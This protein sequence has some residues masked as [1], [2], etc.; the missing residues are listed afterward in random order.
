MARS[1]P[2]PGEPNAGR[3]R[4]GSI[5]WLAESRRSGGHGAL[6]F[7][8]LDNFKP[9][10]DRHGH[11]AGD[12]LLIEAATRL[13]AYVRAMD[14][15]ARFGGDEF[16]VLLSDL[17]ADEAEARLRTR[18]LAD[19]IRLSLAAPYALTLGR[20]GQAETT[21]EHHC[22]ASIGIALF[23]DHRLTADDILREADA[24]MYRA[25]EAGR[26]QIRFHD[27]LDHPSGQS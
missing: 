26:N 3:P 16:V 22:T 15:V 23:I 9:V 2:G 11:E 13:K 20:E 10:N 21:I 18:H 6:M 27:G 14:S 19:K 17:P 24:A 8:D 7:L 5:I 1:I 25:K 12:L 4:K